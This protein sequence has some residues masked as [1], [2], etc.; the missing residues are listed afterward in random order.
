MDGEREAMRE[1]KKPACVNLLQSIMGLSH[2]ALFILMFPQLASLSSIEEEIGPWFVLRAEPPAVTRRSASLIHHRNRRAGS[3][4]GWMWWE[5]GVQEWQRS[6]LEGSVTCLCNRS[7]SDKPAN[8][9]QTSGAE[10]TWPGF[11]STRCFTLQ[12]Q[13]EILRV[14]RPNL[15]FTDTCW[16]RSCDVIYNWRFQVRFHNSLNWRLVSDHFCCWS[17]FLT[18]KIVWPEIN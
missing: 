8:T 9:T 5:R 7:H 6:P 4:C 1:E 13:R 18:S 12:P 10:R 3:G 15:P 14:L 11:R 17:S 16:W 2:G